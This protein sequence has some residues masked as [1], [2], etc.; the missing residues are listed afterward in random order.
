MRKAH[1]GFAAILAKWPGQSELAYAYFADICT[2]T[3]D[4]AS[5]EKALKEFRASTKWK[6]SPK[7]SVLLA[8]YYARSAKPE[9]AEAS[10]KEAMTL[11]HD[12]P[13]VRAKLSHFYASR[14]RYDDAIKALDPNS[15]NRGV[16]EQILQIYIEASRL[17][18]A[19]QLL[20]KL[21]AASPKDTGLRI[22]QAMLQLQEGKLLEAAQKRR[23]GARHRTA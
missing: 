19:E 13:D 5:G 7:P 21:L 3:S 1:D 4:F 23:C 12:A 16:Q 9:L 22:A 8:E 15:P 20:N 14:H 17:T 11:S 6:D 2:Q 18:E 10:F